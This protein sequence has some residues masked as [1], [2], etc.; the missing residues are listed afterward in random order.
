MIEVLGSMKQYLTYIFQPAWPA[1]HGAVLPLYQ[2]ASVCFIFTL[3]SLHRYA[4]M[5]NFLK[6]Y[7]NLPQEKLLIE[8]R[9]I[10][11]MIYT[12]I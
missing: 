12:P 4:R 6:K 10:I 11:I 9:V 1:F 7:N 3:P 2:P 8:N 5:M